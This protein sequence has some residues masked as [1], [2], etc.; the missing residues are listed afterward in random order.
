[1]ITTSKN[2]FATSQTAE[3]LNSLKRLGFKFVTLVLSVK[4]PERVILLFALWGG[5]PITWQL[6]C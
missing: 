2:G 4:P 6:T 5:R 3:I 1:M